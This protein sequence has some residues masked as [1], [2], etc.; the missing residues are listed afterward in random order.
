MESAD[1]DKKSD[2]ASN[3]DEV[4]TLLDLDRLPPVTRDEPAPS[5]DSEE[6]SVSELLRQ[7]AR[8]NRWGLR[9]LFKKNKT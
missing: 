7:R 5:V 6:E 4:A 3:P 1:K 9:N 2:T 8:T